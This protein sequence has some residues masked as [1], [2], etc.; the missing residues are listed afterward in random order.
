MNYK[1][2]GK[3]GGAA[4]TKLLLEKLP[5]TSGIQE[6]SRAPRPLRIEKEIHCRKAEGRKT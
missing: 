2:Q 1:S 4:A 3:N 5:R 6:Q